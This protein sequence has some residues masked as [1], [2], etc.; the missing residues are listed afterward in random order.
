VNTML[1]SLEEQRAVKLRQRLW[2]AAVLIAL[3]VIILPLLLDGSGSESQFRR[4]ERLREEPPRIIDAAGN[5]ETVPIPDAEDSRRD[6]PISVDSRVASSARVETREDELAAVDDPSNEGAELLG[7]QEQE[8][9]ANDVEEERVRVVFSENGEPMS[10]TD[11]L[12]R[13]TASDGTVVVVDAQNSVPD[14]A[15]P[16]V[17]D[18]VVDY[19]LADSADA[20]DSM[21]SMDTTDARELP[22]GLKRTFVEPPTAWVV[23]AGSFRDEDNAVAVRDGLRRDGFPS[24]V[25]SV[26]DGELLYRVQVGPMIDKDV[27]GVTRDKIMKL[28][29]REAIVVTYP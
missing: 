9:R 23:Q 18:Y 25:T 19:A 26:N 3:A 2:G 6:E 5:R 28:L 13:S 20:I 7:E 21:E 1:D 29:N 22:A 8:R 16:D 4:V 15:S 11:L 14:D 10:D 12:D 27:A 17:G 24:F